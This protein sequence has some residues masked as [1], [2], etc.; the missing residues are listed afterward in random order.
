MNSSKKQTPQPNKNS[1]KRLAWIVVGISSLCCILL[2]GLLLVLS[3]HPPPKKQQAH[4]E[5]IIYLLSEPAQRSSATSA[6]PS[7]I[8][9]ELP[10]GGWV[11][12]TDS[13]GNL[14]QQYRCKSLDPDPANRSAGWIE[15]ENLEVELYLG[16]NKL[17][18]ITSDSAIANA[19]NRVLESGE[20]IGNVKVTMFEINTLNNS[21]YPEPLMVLRTDNA[22]F[23]NF[24]GEIT[25]PNEVKVDSQSQTLAG[26]H[27]SLRFNDKEERIE[28]LHLEELEYI[29][30]LPKA[31]V[32]TTGTTT[33]SQT[34]NVVS[35]TPN[36]P[37]VHPATS[38][39]KRVNAA[40]VGSEPEYY[41]VT[42]SDDVQILQGTYENGRIARGNTLTIAF[43]N[44]SKSA[45][46]ST[47]HQERFAPMQP[48]YFAQTIPITLVAVSL[49]AIETPL[50]DQRA[51]VTCSGGLTMVPIEDPTL[52]PS[53]STDTRI[54]LFAFE[55]SPA[56]LIDT[57][58]NMEAYASVLRYELQQ[59][60]SDLFGEPATLLM[61]DMLTSAN[62]LWISRQDGLGGVTGE[63]TMESTGPQPS[64]TSLEWGNGVDFTFNSS[65]VGNEGAL[66]E[67]ICHGDVTLSDQGSSVHCDT[68]TVN[69][70]NS[71]DGS[72]SPSL[73]IANGS[74]KAISDAQTMWADQMRVSFKEK[75]KTNK[76][77]E[78]ENQ[79]QDS[80]FGG[81]QADKMKATGDVQILLRDGG[82]AFCETLDGN[83]SQDIATLQGN[84]VIAYERMFMNRGDSA[85][86]ILNRAS[87]KGQWTGPGQ[88]LFLDTPIHVSQDHR[89]TRPD[90]HTSSET[91]E[92]EPVSMKSTW[93]R[94]MNLD[95]KF[96][97]NAGA[98]EL[99]GEVDIQSERTKNERSK[100]TGDDLRLEFV[101]IKT[102]TEKEKRD[103]EKV[104]AKVNAQIEHRLWDELYP[105][106]PPVVYYIGGNHL[107]FN[108]ISQETLAVGDGEL[109][110]RDPREADTALHHS[111]L[112]GR[113]T[114]RFTWDNKLVSTQ[115]E[116]DAYLLE[117]T[118]NVEMIH[119]GVDGTIGMLTSD[120][121]EAIA[122][123]PNA[124]ADSKTSGN[125]LTLRGL[126]LQ[127]LIANGNVY[128][129]TESK[130]VDC[131]KFNYN[132]ITGFA[133][134]S[135]LTNRSVAIVTDGSPYPVRA[136]SI[137]WN[138]DPSID[139]ITIR[140]L[141]GT[142]TN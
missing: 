41:I 138:M 21:V 32:R 62:H 132:L 72:T 55:D 135:A 79:D 77:S 23:D 115:L 100:M 125:T 11:Q 28:Y 31:T 56:Q 134:L 109:V 106:L 10:Q 47:Q 94:E 4:N 96:N 73:A 14:A 130:R 139:T 90:F 69:F 65:D 38:V 84:V 141:Q 102:N 92:G 37:P 108:L 137:V 83:I 33:S 8:G 91:N 18:R 7:S 16:D 3:E 5:D 2:L 9:I 26:R 129:A 110:L 76:T 53:T 107:E 98:I 93:T 46:E 117:M 48:H 12:Q 58:Q 34:Q 80:M 66:E 44:E 127:K 42:L 68:L 45:T 111:A 51:R 27:L 50:N 13:M 52:I 121:I 89:I 88:A 136:S 128:V 22:T 82:R 122:I 118:G 60:R 120:K 19:P 30:F 35:T 81:T 113:G 104:I 59:D 105:D 64:G 124:S 123:D 87:G 25:C 39:T 97:S 36:L 24:L 71:P 131:D 63:G 99:K 61:N 6:A 57:T 20:I 103:L 54:E 112:A 70:S 86:L 40:A 1:G 140:D 75:Q 15:M 74:V 119:K 133:T 101:K 142:S 116:G 126:D 17:V 49:A 78:I 114:T 85:S 95:Q 29:D 43:S 67:V